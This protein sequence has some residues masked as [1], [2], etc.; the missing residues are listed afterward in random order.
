LSSIGF[1]VCG[2]QDITKQKKSKK[3]M[4][5]PI[6]KSLSFS[7]DIGFFLIIFFWPLLLEEWRKN[8]FNESSTKKIEFPNDLG[9]N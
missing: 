5:C 2:S 6:I 8:I 7:F 3:I 9:F 1:H 4:Q